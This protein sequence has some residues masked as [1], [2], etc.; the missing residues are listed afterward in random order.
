MISKYK[1]ITL[2]GSTRFM[3]I[4]HKVEHDLTLK[5]YIVLSVEVFEKITGEEISKEQIDLLNDIHRKKIDISDAIFVIDMHGYIGEAT[6]SEIE[7]AESLGKEVFYFSKLYTE[8]VVHN[9]WGHDSKRIVSL[10]SPTRRTQVVK[11]TRRLL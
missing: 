8:V 3:D 10:Q 4:F 9:I 2:C 7:Y 5:G 1:V 11:V 6:K